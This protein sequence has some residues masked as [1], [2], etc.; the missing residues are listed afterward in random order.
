VAVTVALDVVAGQSAVAAVDGVVAV[1]ELEIFLLF[2][3]LLYRG[4]EAFFIIFVKCLP[5]TSGQAHDIDLA[6]VVRH[7]QPKVAAAVTLRLHF[8]LYVVGPFLL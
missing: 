3:C 6:F 1:T 8:H 2:L 7:T 5:C 4:P